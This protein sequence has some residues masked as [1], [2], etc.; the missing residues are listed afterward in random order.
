MS[1]E[2]RMKTQVL[3]PES[4]F[5]TFAK[6]EMETRKKKGDFKKSW[7]PP[8]PRAKKCG[9]QAS[10]RRLEANAPTTRVR[11]QVPGATATTLQRPLGR[12]VRG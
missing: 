3:T 5:P 1:G 10:G 12:R 4:A 6:Q 2:G 7:A 9:G 8:S 11:T